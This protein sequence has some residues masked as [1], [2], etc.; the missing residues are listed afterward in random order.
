MNAGASM[1]LTS[2]RPL[3]L[4]GAPGYNNVAAMVKLHG[5]V[6]LLSSVVNISMVTNMPNL[7]LVGYLLHGYIDLINNDC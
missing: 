6:D 3:D 7:K 1:T 5:K 2:M 4:S